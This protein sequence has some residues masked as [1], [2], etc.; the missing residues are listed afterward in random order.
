[1]NKIVREHYPVAN[2]PDDLK[3]GL[4]ADA[5]VRVVLEVEDQPD[6]ASDLYPGLKD[7][8]TPPRKPMTGKDVVEAIK[9]YKALGRPSVTPEEA[10]GRIRE[11]RDEWD[12]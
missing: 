6:V 4:A 7:F 10:V 2:L 5:T 3:G 1:M 8:Q 9:R 12:Y 11:L